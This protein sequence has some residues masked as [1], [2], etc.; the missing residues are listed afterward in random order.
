MIVV[1]TGKYLMR[2]CCVSVLY[3]GNNTIRLVDVEL[4]QTVVYTT[5]DFC[6]P[7]S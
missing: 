7:S 1:S 5:C 3:A 4:E 6:R 2:H